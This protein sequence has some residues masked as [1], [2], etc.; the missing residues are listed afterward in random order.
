MKIIID[1]KKFEG[2]H[3][4]VF[5]NNKFFRSEDVNDLSRK[6]NLILSDKENLARIRKN[7]KTLI[8]E[9]FSWDVIGRLTK[10]AY[11]TL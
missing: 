4:Y 7:G 10:Q 2:C 5:W 9:K 3:Q 11:Q 1:D 8:K 6:L